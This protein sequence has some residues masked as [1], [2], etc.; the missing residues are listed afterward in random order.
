MEPNMVYIA[1]IEITAFIPRVPN[2]FIIEAWILIEICTSNS[3]SAKEKHNKTG[4]L[5]IVSIILL[6]IQSMFSLMRNEDRR[7]NPIA[8]NILT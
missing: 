4:S 3:I 2:A 7:T 1:P 5:L 6:T 8:P